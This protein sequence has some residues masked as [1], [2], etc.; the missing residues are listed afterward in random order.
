MPSMSYCRFQTTLSAFKDCAESI[1]DNDLSR[2]EAR[3]REQLIIQAAALLDSLG[4]TIDQ[5]K[6]EQ[7]I[8][9]LPC[10]GDLTP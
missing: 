3:A 4:V 10:I 1:C 9:N 8:N 6:V 2:N 7:A 5:E